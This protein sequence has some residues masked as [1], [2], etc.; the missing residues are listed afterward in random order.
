MSLTNMINAAFIFVVRAAKFGLLFL[1]LIVLII[2]ICIKTVRPQVLNLCD[3]R[4]VDTSIQFMFRDVS[5]LYALE[6]SFK[7]YPL[8]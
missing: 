1:Q 7:T 2:P 3:W 4:S 8:L 6:S 5:K